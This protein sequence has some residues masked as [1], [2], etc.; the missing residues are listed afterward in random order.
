MNELK[1]MFLNKLRYEPAMVVTGLQNIV[2]GIIA[3]VGYELGDVE[4]LGVGLVISGL[5][6]LVTEKLFVRDVVTPV[7]KLEDKEDIK[8]GI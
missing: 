3:I 7:A 6:S 5:V 8:Y 4:G 2:M 1:E